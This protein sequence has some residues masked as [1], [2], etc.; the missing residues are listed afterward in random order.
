MLILALVLWLFT[1]DWAAIV[2]PALK[3]VPR[4]EI[5]NAKGEGGIC[6]SVIINGPKGFALTAAHCVDGKDLAFTVNGRLAMVVR[7][8]RINDLAV[9]HYAPKNETSMPLADKTPEIGTDIA[10]VGYPFGVKDVAAQFGRIAQSYN[11]ETKMI[12][13]NADLIFGDSGGAVIDDQGRLIGL[14]SA[15]F[16]EGPAHMAAAI[17]IET[18]RDFVDEFLP[19]AAK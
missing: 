14:N 1:P 4:V 7:V 2:K 13:I 16:Y 17:P 3:Q 15:I 9:L 19:K 8:D 11:A 12:W 18:I 10:V 6:S 5:Q